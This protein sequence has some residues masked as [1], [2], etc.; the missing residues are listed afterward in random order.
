M[1]KLNKAPHVSIRPQVHIVSCARFQSII[2]GFAVRRHCAFIL[3]IVRLEPKGK[4][5][6]YCRISRAPH[7]AVQGP[8]GA[9]LVYAI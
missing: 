5:D 4:A 6:Y 7:E 3:T 8:R 9:S 1:R 2:H